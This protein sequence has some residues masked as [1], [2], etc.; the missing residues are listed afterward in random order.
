MTDHPNQVPAEFV[1]PSVWRNP[2]HF[3]AFGLGSGTLPKAPGTWGS[4][5]GLA[6]VPLL[7]W[8]PLWGYAGVLLAALQQGAAFPQT[9]LAGNGWMSSGEES[10]R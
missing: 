2:W 10:G 8:L 6:A 5:L 9:W 4:L 7:Q 1:P 3:L